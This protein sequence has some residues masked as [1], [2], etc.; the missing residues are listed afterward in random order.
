MIAL[1]GRRIL[2]YGQPVDMRKGFTGLY[3]LVLQQL[4]EDPQSGDAFV[5]INRTGSHLKCFLWD[6]TGFVILTK[7]LEN[8][9][10]RLRNPA[11]K[12]EIDEKR[13]KLL[14][15]GVKIGGN[16]A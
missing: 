15:D 2:A 3:G 16:S 8:G 10:F 5:F 11:E 4:R 1:Q 14:M 7:R 9:R 12:L 6:R 13:L